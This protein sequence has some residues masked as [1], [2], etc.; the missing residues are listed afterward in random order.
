M[1]QVELYNF[2]LPNMGRRFLRKTLRNKRLTTLALFMS[3]KGKCR[4]QNVD[5]L[6]AQNA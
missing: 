6:C 1:F 3:E 5:Q 2:V 4:I